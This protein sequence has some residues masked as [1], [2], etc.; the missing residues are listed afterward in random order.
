MADENK[1]MNQ[2]APLRRILEGEVVS[3]KMNKTVVVSVGRRFKHPVIGKTIN[4]SKHYKVHDEAG[5]AK[6]G[7]WVEIVECAPISK[8]K[9]MRLSKVLKAAV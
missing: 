9:H 7:D 1:Q 8:T 2:Q 3:D 6:C 5:L 4:R